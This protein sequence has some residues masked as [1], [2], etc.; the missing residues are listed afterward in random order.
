MTLTART[1]KIT[2]ILL[3]S[4]AMAFIMLVAYFAFFHVSSTHEIKVETFRVPGGWGYQIISG[5]RVFIYQP[6]IPGLPGKKP[7]P[8]KSAALSAAKTIREKLLQGKRP[9]L[10][11]DEI[12]KAGVDSLGNSK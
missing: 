6:F 12:L 2:R 10:S 4:F 8:R 3:L 1:I 7:F 11:R 9:D 5:D